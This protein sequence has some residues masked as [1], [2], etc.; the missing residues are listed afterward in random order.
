MILTGAGVRFRQDGFHEWKDIASS[1]IEKTTYQTKTE[2]GTMISGTR[3]TLVVELV[4]AGILRVSADQLDKAPDQI[5]M[6]FEERK[7]LS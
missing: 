3:H 5:V 1:R 2:E 4:N 7:F 6:L